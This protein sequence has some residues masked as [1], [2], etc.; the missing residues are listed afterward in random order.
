MSTK[1]K[2]LN[3]NKPNFKN[4]KV[5]FPTKINVDSNSSIDNSNLLFDQFDN[6]LQ[7]EKTL[8]KR[9]QIIYP[10]PNKLTEI[11]E[12]ENEK[13]STNITNKK[14]HKQS[15]KYN[16]R[17]NKGIQKGKKGKRRLRGKK[18]LNILLR[19]KSIRSNP[20]KNFYNSKRKK[21]KIFKLFTKQ[22]K[23]LN[24]KNIKK[25][26][27][28]SRQKKCIKKNIII[29]KKNLKVKKS[30]ENKKIVFFSQTIKTEINGFNE[31]QDEE[32]YFFSLNKE[33]EEKM[34]LFN[35]DNIFN[36]EKANISIPPNKNEI[37]QNEVKKEEIN[38]HYK[39]SF[40]SIGQNQK[41][42]NNNILENLNLNEKAFP[43][44]EN[45]ISNHEKHIIFSDNNS[46]ENNQVDPNLQNIPEQAN[47]E[48]IQNDFPQFAN[49]IPNLNNND[50]ELEDFNNLDD[51]PPENENLNEEDIIPDYFQALAHNN[52]RYLL[53]HF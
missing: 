20:C 37:N 46:G 52:N 43:Q 7:E 26:K 51:L 36:S 44:T 33:K 16:K 28:C 42:S 2:S 30:R 11:D 19:K 17:K 14:S 4:N 34:N 21:N 53:D 45:N 1:K 10:E 48:A 49:H 25:S 3:K 12:N 5:I 18:L 22:K 41:E 6:S 27:N 50:I 35:I 29:E 38:N 15:K 32:E 9:V 23:D 31:N 40:S 8:A 24:F 47:F 13:R 39:I